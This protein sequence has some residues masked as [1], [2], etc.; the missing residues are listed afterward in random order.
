L[1]EGVLQLNI[2]AVGP[3]SGSTAK[4]KTENGAEA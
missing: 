4:L 3:M 1:R 2:P